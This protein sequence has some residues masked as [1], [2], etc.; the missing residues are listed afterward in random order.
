MIAQPSRL[1]A[2]KGTTQEVTARPLSNTISIDGRPSTQRLAFGAA[3]EGGRPSIKRER[4]RLSEPHRSAGGSMPFAGRCRDRAAGRAK[5]RSSV[6]IERI[7][8][9]RC[10][11]TEDRRAVLRGDQSP[12]RQC[13]KDCVTPALTPTGGAFCPAD[14]RVAFLLI[15]RAVDITNGRDPF[16]VAGKAPRCFNG[17]P[18]R[19]ENRLLA[20]QRAHRDGT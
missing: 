1:A 9:A 6:V 16:C 13:H 2:K 17:K 10:D 4:P 12:R 7:E 15:P 18:R 11:K 8:S 19:Q 20:D 5:A 14:E 3:N